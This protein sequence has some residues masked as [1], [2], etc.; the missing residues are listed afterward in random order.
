MHAENC[1]NSWKS[2]GDTPH[3]P[4]WSFLCHVPNVMCKNNRS[5]PGPVRSGVVNTGDV[6]PEQG[7]G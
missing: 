1:D 4:G 3:C 2:A 5:L 7:V 6:G